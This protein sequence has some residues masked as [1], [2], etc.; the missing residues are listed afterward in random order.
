MSY[1]SK[2]KLSLERI[3]YRIGMVEILEI[4]E[5]SKGFTKEVTTIKWQWKARREPTVEWK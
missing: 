5:V 2:T 4:M 1:F 3:T